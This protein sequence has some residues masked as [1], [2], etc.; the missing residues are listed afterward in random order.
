VHHDESNQHEYL[1]ITQAA[2]CLGVSTSWVRRHL[3][4]LP[5]VRFGR[6]IRVSSRLLSEVLAAKLAGGKSLKSERGTMLSRYQRGMV[7]QRGKSRVWYGMFREDIQTLEGTT[8][9]T[10]RRQKMVRLGTVAELPTKGAARNKLAELMNS[11]SE[12]PT[13]MTFTELSTRWTNVEGPTLKTSTLDH[14]TNALHAYVSPAFGKR[15]IGVINREDIQTFL[16]EKAKTYSTS[17]LRSMRAVLGLTLGWANACGWIPRNPCVKV[18]LPKET[19]GKR[20]TRTVLTTEQVN[21]IVGV[22]REPYATLVLLLAE[23]G[24]RISEAI[25]VRSEDLKGNVLSVS[26]RVY[27]GATDSVKSARAVRSIPLSAALVERI[28]ALNQQGLIFRSRAGTVINPNNAL[29]RYIKG[30]HGAA[31]KLGIAIGGWHDFRHTLATNLRRAGA[32]PKVVS[33]ILG[34][35]RVNL[36]MDTYDHTDVQ[37]FS[38]AL[39]KVNGLLASVSKSPAAA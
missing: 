29:K 12:K 9:I 17:T 24:L 4:E 25:A 27:D 1:T 10:E 2:V 36:A 3:A 37:D 11:P 26:R 8:Q 18:R 38:D 30:D 33:G 21:S 5:V 6:T 7:F 34:H 20:V 22:L 14:Y 28:R 19:G 15:K 35:A 13:D 16:A 23:T 39:V 31:T 32:H